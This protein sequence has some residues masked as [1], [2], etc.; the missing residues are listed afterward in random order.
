MRP[1]GLRHLF[2]APS[3]RPRA[4]ELRP[5]ICCVNTANPQINRGTYTL[6]PLFLFA[7][8][9]MLQRS[10]APGSALSSDQVS[11]RRGCVR[12]G[13]II[14]QRWLTG[15]VPSAL[16]SSYPL[17]WSL[18]DG[19]T[20]DILASPSTVLRS[21]AIS[22]RRPNLNTSREKISRVSSRSALNSLRTPLGWQWG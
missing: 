19:F 6:S 5:C 7:L 1:F 11:R 4:F 14:G 22:G 9:S 2:A 16:T 17:C 15:R 12:T 20:R 10:N 18:D 8:L 13:L 3:P 21:A